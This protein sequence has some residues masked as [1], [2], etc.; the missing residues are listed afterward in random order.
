MCSSKIPRSKLDVGKEESSWLSQLP[1]PLNNE[2]SSSNELN[3][4]DKD[5]T[6]DWVLAAA[7]SAC[8]SMANKSQQNHIDDGKVKWD[9]DEYDEKDYLNTPSS[10]NITVKNQ[11]FP[12]VS[13]ASKSWNDNEPP[14][15]SLISVDAEQSEDPITGSLSKSYKKGH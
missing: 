15:T 4:A 2:V 13:A 9:P 5:S 7:Q 11:L 14:Q 1:F 12:Y 8:E 3:F 10:S 6:S